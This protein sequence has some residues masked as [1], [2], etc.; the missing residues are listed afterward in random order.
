M[1]RR[2]ISAAHEPWRILAPRLVRL[3]SALV[4]VVGAAAAF[5]WALDRSSARGERYV[6]GA[7]LEEWTPR[8]SAASSETRDSAVAAVGELIAREWAARVGALGVD[9]SAASL[10][11]AASALT[12]SLADSDTLVRAHAVGVIAEMLERSAIAPSHRAHEPE[13]T[14]RPL[15]TTVRR[16]ALAV[17]REATGPPR[18]SGPSLAALQLRRAV[19]VPQDALPV[20]IDVAGHD[21]S[22]TV[23]A[24]ALALVVPASAAAPAAPSATDSLLAGALED[25]AT[26]LRLAATDALLADPTPACRNASVRRALARLR[27]DRHPAI[28][29]AAGFVLDSIDRARPHGSQCASA[30]GRQVGPPRR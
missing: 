27:S 3:L 23:R 19:G 30:V 7:P 14:T 1:A 25:S 18:R 9:P 12:R 8:L 26:D 2:G 17:L 20:V 13:T 22:P 16:T 29:A 15:A 10:L 28:R 24:L 4:V 6:W 5:A 21:S 11:A